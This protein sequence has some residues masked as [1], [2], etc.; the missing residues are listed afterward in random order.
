[1]KN[2]SPPSPLLLLSS[3]GRGWTGLGAQFL[4]LPPG[5]AA[6]AG[7]DAHVLGIH[8]GAPVNA[9]CRVG[10]VRARGLQKPGD[11]GFIPAGIDGCWE[12]DA[13][14]QLLRLALHDDVFRAVAEEL[15]HDAGRIELAPRPRFRDARTEAIGWAIKSDLESDVP[16]DPLYVGHL[17][18]ALA[19]RVI[20]VASGRGSFGDDAGGKRLSARQMKTLVDFIEAHL[21]QRLLLEDLAKVIGVSV[22]VLKTLFRHTTGSP[23][24]QYVIRRRAEYAR[25]LLTTTT[26]PASQIALAAGFAHQGHMTATMRRLLGQ[27]P[28]HIT[29]PSK[30]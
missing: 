11:I 21:D 1:M 20:H 8:Y 14:C 24:H 4:K 28:R 15:G 17:A 22:T 26:L 6:R 29:R 23:V 12:D 5:R 16:S 25:V 27:I 7:E 9:D 19:V 13:D 2:H 10:D 3:E 18:H 30:H